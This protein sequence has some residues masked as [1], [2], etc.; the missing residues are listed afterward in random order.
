M[1]KRVLIDEETIQKRIHQL[2]ES[3]NHDYEGKDL[4]LICI[5]KGSLYFFSDL[6]RRIKGDPLIEFMR[7]KSYEGE[8]STGIIEIRVDLDQSIKGKDVLIIE[9]IIDSGNTLS[10]LKTYLK[11]KKPNSIR[12]CTLLDKP[13]RRDKKIKINVDYVGFTI[14][15]RFVIGYGLDLDEQYRAIPEIHCFTDDDEEKLQEEREEIQKQ[16]VKTKRTR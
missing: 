5:L 7:V 16:L 13:D 4:T 11:D 3:I 2:A 15:D 1:E 6:S 8:N 12:I 10:Y 14:K 9:D